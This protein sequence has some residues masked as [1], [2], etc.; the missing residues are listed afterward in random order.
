M[1]A[2]PD[3]IWPAGLTRVP[4]WV[5][6][7][8]DVLALEQ[9]RIFEGPV[10]NFLCLETELPNIG[11]YRTTFIGAMP[12]VVARAE[13]GDV[14]AFENRCAHRGAL[15]CLDDSG[16][17]EG[18]P[19]RLSRLALRPARQSALDRVQRAASTARGGM[20]A[21]FDMTQHGPRKLRVTTF[22]GMVFGT[23]SADA[24]EFEAWLGPEIVARVRRV[25]GNRRLEIIGR[26]TQALP[27]NW[28]LYFENVRDTYHASLLHLFFATFRITRLQ[29]RRW[30]TGQRD[31][32]APCIGHAAP[33]RSGADT[34]IR[35][36][37]PTRR[38]SASPIPACS[39]C[40]TSSTTT[41]N[42][43]SCRFS[44]ASS[45]NRCTTHWRCGRS[46]RAASMR[47]T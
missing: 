42:C 2:I 37:A 7:D 26:F 38:A 44:R 11:D 32:R 9:K 3:R 29:V 25:L 36:C 8:P 4:Y 46:C 10:W 28:K 13:D 39:A 15:I 21:D 5:Y 14:S 35:A 20:P 24:P 17:G 30:R 6:T 41:S 12:V 22:C 18:L 19:V 23:L 33:H 31:R 40:T 34:A 43:R 45:C 47:P 27:N 16:S 1:D